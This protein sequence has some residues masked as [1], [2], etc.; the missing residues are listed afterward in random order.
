MLAIGTCAPVAVFVM[1]FVYSYHVDVL[2]GHRKDPCDTS[3]VAC[4][5]MDRVWLSCA[6]YRNGRVRAHLLH[7]V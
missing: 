7:P 2:C 1:E 5:A 6:S 4:L 3:S